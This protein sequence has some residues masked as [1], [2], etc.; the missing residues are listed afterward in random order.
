MTSYENWLLEYVGDL[1]NM[2]EI[3]LREIDDVQPFCDMDFTEREFGLFCKMVY[4]TSYNT[5]IDFTESPTDKQR[6]IINIIK[7]EPTEF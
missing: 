4:D 5:K 3:V 6:E 7:H 2:F 1:E